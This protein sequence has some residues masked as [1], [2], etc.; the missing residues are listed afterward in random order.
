MAGGPC[1]ELP[2]EGSSRKLPVSCVPQPPGSRKQTAGEWRR[3]SERR[4]TGQGWGTRSAV[5]W[6]DAGSRGRTGEQGMQTT[7]SGGRGRKGGWMEGRAVYSRRQVRRISSRAG[8]D[9]SL[10]GSDGM[11]RGPRRAQQG[12]TTTQQH[13][14]DR[15]D[16]HLCTSKQRRRPHA[17]A[18]RRDCAGQGRAVGDGRGRRGQA[19]KPR[20]RAV[21][22][23]VLLRCRCWSSTIR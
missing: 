8:E 22:V 6:G 3:D 16:L 14:R 11:G 7:W 1:Q 19:P 2:R 13:Q 17:G 15:K 4:T 18:G 5:K 12:W 21:A 23:A 20:L 10:P 9:N